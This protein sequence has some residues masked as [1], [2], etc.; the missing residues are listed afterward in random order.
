MLIEP[1]TPP[2]L[3]K[4]IAAEKPDAILP[5]VGGQTGLNLAL[6]LAKLGILEKYN[7]RLIGASVDA[8]ELAED[9]QLFSQAMAEIG[10]RSPRSTIVNTQEGIETAL[11]DIGVPAIVRPSF[12]MG[13]TGGGMAYTES[14][15]RAAVQ[16]GMDASPQNQVLVEQSIAGWKEYELEVM[17]DCVDNVV[18]ICSIENLDP[19]GVHTGDSIT[20]AP[21]QTLTDR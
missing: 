20:V 2:I 10:I 5:T 8:I 13:G 7:V 4:I 21:A 1:L 15:F 9:R 12:T 19:M 17:R 16:K 6:D 11:A 14:E 3:E 18:I